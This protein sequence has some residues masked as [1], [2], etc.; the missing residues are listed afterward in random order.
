MPSILTKG[1]AQEANPA[2]RL[3]L[4]LSPLLITLSQEYQGSPDK[5]RGVVGSPDE[6]GGLFSPGPKKTSYPCK[7]GRQ[8]WDDTEAV[9]VRTAST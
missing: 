1:A 8:V 4:Y 3:F 7:T 5:P 2:Q 6:Y 9:R